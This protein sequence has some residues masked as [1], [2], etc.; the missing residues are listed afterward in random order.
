M[1]T[2]DEL[3]NRSNLLFSHGQRGIESECIAGQNFGIGYVDVP[4]RGMVHRIAVF[5]YHIR[6][7]NAPPNAE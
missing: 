4:R 1:A 6:K 2:F 5:E 7:V 3:Q